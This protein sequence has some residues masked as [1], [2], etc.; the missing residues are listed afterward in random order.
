MP[1]SI[2]GVGVVPTQQETK[3]VLAKCKAK[4]KSKC[5]Y[6]SAYVKL[7]TAYSN[8]F[9]SGGRSD[10]VNAVEAVRKAEIEKANNTKVK[11]PVTETVFLEGSMELNT[12]AG[13]EA[14]RVKEA[15]LKDAIGKANIGAVI[16]V[17]KRPIGIF[18]VSVPEPK[19]TIFTKTE[20]GWES[21][22]YIPL[23]DESMFSSGAYSIYTSIK[24]PTGRIA[25]IKQ[26][27]PRKAEFE[28]G[29]R[30][31]DGLLEIGDVN[32]DG[33]GTFRVTIREL[34]GGGPKGWTLSEK[35]MTQK[36]RAFARRAVPMAHLTKSAPAPK[37]W[38]Q[39]TKDGSGV[40]TFLV[41]RLD[42]DKEGFAK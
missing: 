2:T 40:I 20:K 32:W 30:T 10:F 17:N 8:F 29:D 15:K 23:D 37:G 33:N 9:S 36:A 18:G 19:T 42:L 13:Q 22:E 39:P 1:Q 41:S 28:I 7:D 31:P 11:F 27:D 3:T 16:T 14:Q 24:N 35:A 38:S 34:I 21:N 12:E 26:N 5:P 4:D 25:K 6:H